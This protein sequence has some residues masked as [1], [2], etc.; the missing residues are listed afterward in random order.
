[1]HKLKEEHGQ[2]IGEN[3]ELKGLTGERNNTFRAQT[4]NLQFHAVELKR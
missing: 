1:M 3:E 2:L 4:L